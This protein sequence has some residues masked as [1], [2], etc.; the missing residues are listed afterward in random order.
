MAAPLEILRQ[1]F[2]SLD[3]PSLL[4][5]G[6]FPPEVPISACALGASDDKA[7]NLLG[8]ARNRPSQISLK[9]YRPIHMPSSKRVPTL[10]S[11]FQGSWMTNA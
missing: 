10:E 6:R 9:A 2:R 8:P 3:T 5:L 4:H 1:I 7:T 11:H